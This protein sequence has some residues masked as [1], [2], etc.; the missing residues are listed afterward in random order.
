MIGPAN[1]ALKVIGMI[2][3]AWRVFVSPSTPL[4]VKIVLGAGLLYV[5]VPYDIIPEWIPLIGML[6]DLALFALL[7]AWANRYTVD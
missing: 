5:L 7:I 2:R 6:D 4:F 1:T 3:H